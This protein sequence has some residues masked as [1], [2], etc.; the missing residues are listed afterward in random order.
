MRTK[1][2]AFWYELRT[3][4]WFV[5]TLMTAAAIGLAFVMLSVD[6]T[7]EQPQLRGLSWIYSGGAEGARTMLST[8]AG[9]MITVAGV[10]TQPDKPQGRS[11]SALVA[12]AVKLVAQAEGLPVLQ[13]ARPVGDLFLAALRRLEP[14][15]GV[16][17]A[18][19]HILRRE[20]LDQSPGHLP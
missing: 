20:V 6:R 9:S 13:P 15:L 5:P 7:L 11:R 1:L 12:P 8:V 17:V 14:D 19:G 10:V 18:Y 2:A 16:V 3:S 4:Y